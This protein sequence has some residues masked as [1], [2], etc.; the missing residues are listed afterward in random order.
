MEV[1]EVPEAV[2]IKGA[3][4]TP[5]ELISR[6]QV[7]VEG[8]KIVYVGPEEPDVSGQVLDFKDCFVVPGLIDL[9][10][11]GGGGYDV[12]GGS[13][14]NLDGLSMFLAAGG[15]TSFF[16]TT[17]SAPQEDLLESA[18]RAREAATEGTEG[19]N[20]LGLHV[21]GPYINPKMVGAQDEDHIRPPSTDE[22]EE[23]H[24]A[25]GGVLRIVTLAPEV[26][27]ALEAVEWLRYRGVIP[28]AGHTDATYEK[29][30]EGVD[31]GISHVAH[32][33]NRMRPLHHREPGAVGAALLDERVSVE[34][35]ADGVHLHPSVLRLAAKS[36]GS[37]RTALVSDGIAP[38][39]L[40]DGEYRF[41]KEKVRVER[42]RCVLGSGVLAGSAIRLCDAVR[43]TV[44]AGFPITESVEMASTTPAGIIGVDDYKGR[45]AE[46]MDADLTVMSRDF[47]VLL[48]LVGGRVVYERG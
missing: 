29:M 20:V 30:I 46:E 35:I 2:V 32:L 22:L 26:E 37:R 10:V 3:V 33:F 16:A 23:I 8:G 36:K 4:V 45:L 27:G 19:A 42:G 21:E 5:K 1:H 18:R 11:H 43:N 28:S 25:A 41:G 12:M 40:P 13:E 24:R 14:G 15:V 38:T 9:H 31:A 7:S 6:G 47:S 48:T 44:D 17:Y 39:G 34:L